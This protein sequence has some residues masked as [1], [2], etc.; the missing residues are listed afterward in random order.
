MDIVDTLKDIANKGI[1]VKVDIIGGKEREAR[2]M[3][4]WRS[5]E[6]VDNSIEKLKEKFKQKETENEK[7][8]T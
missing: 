6:Q 5:G 7:Q 3:K 2:K 8:N 4:A 1:S